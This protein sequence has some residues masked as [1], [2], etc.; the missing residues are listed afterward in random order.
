MTQKEFCDKYKMTEAQ[1]LG[2]EKFEGNLDRND[3][4]D[5]I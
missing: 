4:R 1:F 5:F 2:H 3:G